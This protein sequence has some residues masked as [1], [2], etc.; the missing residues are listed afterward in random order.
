MAPLLPE[1][2][3]FCGNSQFSGRGAPTRASELA[4]WSHDRHVSGYSLEFD[5]RWV[6]NVNYSCRLH[7]LTWNVTVVGLLPH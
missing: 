3:L 6:I 7:C 2:R 4:P 1:S 5:V